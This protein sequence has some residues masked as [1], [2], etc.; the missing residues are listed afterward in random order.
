M[1]QLPSF[2]LY[3]HLYLRIYL[4]HGSLSLSAKRADSSMYFCSFNDLRVLLPSYWQISRLLSIDLKSY[5]FLGYLELC[6][7]SKSLGKTLSLE[8]VQLKLALNTNC[9]DNCLKMFCILRTFLSRNHIFLVRCH[10]YYLLYAPLNCKSRILTSCCRKRS[11]AYT[12]RDYPCSS[13]YNC[14]DP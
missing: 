9:F 13:S 4:K 1:L 11:L 2:L 12:Q 5:L 3:C 7:S 8:M 6:T 10:T 14:T